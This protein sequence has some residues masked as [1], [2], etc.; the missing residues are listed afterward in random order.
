[1]NKKNNIIK[2]AEIV[3][4]PGRT[5]LNPTFPTTSHVVTEKLNYVPFGSDNCFPQAIAY[6][7]RKAAIHRGILNNITTY[8]AGWGFV[9]DEKE[10]DLANY[11]LSCNAHN[12]SLR[13][14]AKRYFFDKRSFGNAWLQLVTNANQDFL[15]IYHVDSVRCRLG[16]LE[17]EGKVLMHPNWRD[18]NNNKSLVKKMNLFPKWEDT[19]GDGNLRCMIHIKEYESEF[20]NYGVPKW[21][22][23]LG[24]SKI[25]YKTDTWNESRLDNG[26]KYSGLLV[27]DGEFK[28]QEEEQKFDHD[29]DSKFSGEGK[30]GGVLKIK[31]PMESDGSKFIP[32][33]TSSEGDWIHLN[34]QSTSTLI[35]A[36]QWFRA[37]SGIADNTGFDTQRIMN[38]YQVALR[39]VIEDEQ[40]EFIELIRSIIQTVLGYD[41]SSLSI[42]N[43]PPIIDKPGYIRIWE[44]RKAD[45][46]PYDENDPTQQLYLA[47]LGRAKTISLQ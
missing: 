6:L 27:V 10:K 45:G 30:Q 2:S 17:D 24:S 22:A 12:E 47:E 36:H 28:S 34:S 31:K 46:M 32:F 41:T 3:G 14:I 20:D 21:I 7:N 29:L 5:N 26:F 33:E 35:V 1:M 15:N 4:S 18:Y 23:G 19:E 8:L 13:K 44:A 9:C 43:R 25:Q 42:V 38:E 11:I 37:L 39:T 16:K 40:Q